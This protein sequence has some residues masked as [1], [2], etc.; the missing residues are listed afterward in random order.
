MKTDFTILT[1]RS[2]L[3]GETARKMQNEIDILTSIVSKY[4]ELVDLKDGIIDMYQ[5]TEIENCT[6][7]VIDMVNTWIRENRSKS[8]VDRINTKSEL[9]THLPGI[10]HR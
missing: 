1:N 6:S 7:T 8:P 3:I 4:K 2:G 9:L 10:L 5:K